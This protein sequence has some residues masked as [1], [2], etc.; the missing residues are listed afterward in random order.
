MASPGRYTSVIHV[1]HDVL[2]LNR[3]TSQNLLHDC[4]DILSWGKSMTVSMY[5][6][7]GYLAIRQPTRTGVFLIHPF[8]SSTSTNLQVVFV[9]HVDIF[10]HLEV[11]C[12]SDFDILWTET[13]VA[14]AAEQPEGFEDALI[15]C[16][17]V[18]LPCCE[19]DCVLFLLA[20]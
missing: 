2:L 8:D 11:T 9:I 12:Q 3:P 5:A 20:P 6:S 4:I 15:S 16:F 13:H 1:R 18:M 10:F 14:R 19:E 7:C 17:F